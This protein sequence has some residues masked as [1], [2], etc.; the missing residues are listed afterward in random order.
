MISASPLD[1][2]KAKIKALKAVS[3]DQISSTAGDIKVVGIIKN[4]KKI[5]TKKKEQM[6]YITIYDDATELELTVF[7]EAY[8]KSVSSIKRNNIVVVD[9]YYRSFKDEFNVTLVTSLEEK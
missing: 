2:F 3:L 8:A 4:I 1:A 9:G 6:A 7:P 5:T